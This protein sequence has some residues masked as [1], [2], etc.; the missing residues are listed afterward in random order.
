MLLFLF[1]T[2]ITTEFQQ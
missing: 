2:S 1:Q